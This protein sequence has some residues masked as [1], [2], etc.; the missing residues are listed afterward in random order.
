MTRNALLQQIDLTDDDLAQEDLPPP[1]N[2]ETYD[3]IRDEKN[4]TGTSATVTDDCRVNNRINHLNRRLSQI[5]TSALHQ[6]VQDGE[7]SAP[8]IPP[9]IPPSLG[10]T[11]DIPQPPRLNI[12]IQVVG[13]RGDVQPFFALGKF[14]RET[15]GHRVRVATRPS[16]FSIGGDPTQL[17]AFMVTD[18]GLRPGF[19]SVASRDAH[20][21]R[22]DVTDP[23]SFAHIHCAEKLDIPLHIVFPMP[24]S[25]TQAFPHP[26]A[27]I[28][29]SNTEP[30]L[31]NYFSYAM[32]EL[33]SW[34]GPGDIINRFRAKCLEL[35]PLSRICSPGALQPL[36]PKPKDWASYISI[37]VFYFL[38]LAS[39]YATTSKLQVFL[40]I[41]PSPIYTGFGSIVLNN[42]DA[43]T[44]L[45]FETTKKTGQR[46]L[47]SNGWGDVGR[48]ELHSIPD[49]GFMLGSVLHE[50]LFKH[51][52]CVVYHGGAGTT[53]AGITAGRPTVAVSFFGDQPFGGSMVSR[54]GTGP[55][56]IPRKQLTAEKSANAI[57]FWLR[58]G[59]LE[60][61]KEIASRITAEQGCDMGARLFQQFLEPD[62]LHCSL[63]PS[64]SVAWR[65]KHTKDLK[66][67]RSQEHYIDKGPWGPIS[68]GFTTF[69]GAVGGMMMGLADVPSET[70]RHLQIPAVQSSFS[71]V[72][73][74]QSET[75]SIVEDSLAHIQSLDDV[76]DRSS[77]T[78]N[79]G[80]S[81]MLGPLH[82]QSRTKQENAS[83]SR[84]HS[85]S[86]SGPSK[87][88]DML[89]PTGVNMSKGARRFVKA[90]VQE[91]VDISLDLTRGMHDTP[92]LWRNDTMRPQERVSGLRSGVKAAGREFGSGFYDSITGRVTQPWR[93][94]HDKGASGFVKGV[95]KGIGGFLAKLGDSCL[96][97]LSH[98]VQG[99]S[100]EVQKL[101]G[102]NVQ[103]YIA[104]SCNSRTDDTADTARSAWSANSAIPR[105]QNFDC[106]TLAIGGLQF[107]LCTA[108]MIPSTSLEVVEVTSREHEKEDTHVTKLQHHE[109]D[110]RT[111]QSN[112]VTERREVEKM[113][114]R[115]AAVTAGSFGRQRRPSFDPGHLGGTT[116][117]DFEAEQKGEQREKIRQENTEQEIV[118]EYIEKQT[119][120]E[121]HR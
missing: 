52:S 84:F 99:F 70:W 98:T 103:N 51:V 25:S 106:T 117:I 96:G 21:R 94:A 107:P 10:G 33:L 79:I 23:P 65:L 56:P 35:H 64:R 5:F 54:A 55:D 58:P 39:N 87:D 46:V 53:A 32:K 15:Y 97:I 85:W 62:R 34:Q 16:F 77:P 104:A 20:Q 75:S 13:F 7:D 72:P 3:E 31:T 48:D 68:G 22:K 71:S 38:N 91:P 83:L 118:S 42:P 2:G 100:K 1:A 47:L 14:L 69:F 108:R 111:D 93:G 81:S 37:S 73:L 120:L 40:D 90:A 86:E 78:S 29:S 89:R 26:L 116:R 115:A 28:Q 63:A 67:Y 19:R 76:S 6:H 57:N 92:K 109:Q 113:S 24:Y 74:R 11:E 8:P 61:A 101:F 44:E 95:G 102:D 110:Y 60:Q 18:P 59:S 88:P 66:L 4:G 80:S 105:I 17:M 114:E 30:Q 112:F 50:W 49:G 36:L 27:N 9:Y 121:V 12:V 82:G 43:M 41:G 45:I 119:L